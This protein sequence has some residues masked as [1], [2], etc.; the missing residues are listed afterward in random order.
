MRDWEPQEY[1]AELPSLAVYQTEHSGMF[2]KAVPSDKPTPIPDSDLVEVVF[3]DGLLR[4]R[5]G[6]NTYETQAAQR[7]GLQLGQQGFA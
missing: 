6:G 2:G 1:I 4:C 3:I 5:G 7:Q